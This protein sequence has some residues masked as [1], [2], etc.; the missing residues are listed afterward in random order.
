[1]KTLVLAAGLLLTGCGAPVAAAT[2][3]SAPAP[4]PAVVTPTAVQPTPCFTPYIA[5]NGART[6]KVGCPGTFNK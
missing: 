6:F 1:M 3:H 2:Q 5:A 4:K